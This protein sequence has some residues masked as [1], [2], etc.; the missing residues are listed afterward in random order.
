[1]SRL[2]TWA[3]FASPWVNLRLRRVKPVRTDIRDIRSFRGQTLPIKRKKKKVFEH[4]SFKHY[5][6][7]NLRKIV[8]KAF[9][10]LTGNM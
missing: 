10:L 4:L 5:V 3:L 8:I 1:M 7:L 6:R 9:S 2:A